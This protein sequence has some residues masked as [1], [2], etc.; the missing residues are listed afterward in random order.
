ML[1]VLHV[2][3]SSSHNNPEVGGVCTTLHCRSR[4]GSENLLRSHPQDERKTAGG[5]DMQQGHE[6]NLGARSRKQFWLVL[7][8]DSGNC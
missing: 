5:E 2:I 6:G 3:S 7:Q 4:V 8:R 1:E